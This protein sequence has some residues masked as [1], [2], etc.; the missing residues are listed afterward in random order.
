MPLGE[1]PNLGVLMKTLILAMLLALAL[2]ACGRPTPYLTR[3]CN[4]ENGFLEPDPN[5][6]NCKDIGW[7]TDPAGGGYQ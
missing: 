3:V 2:A 6:P 5:L 7:E 4:A 1:P